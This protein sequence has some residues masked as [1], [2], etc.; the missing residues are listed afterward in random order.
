MTPGLI[1]RHQ[2]YVLGPNQ[3]GRLAS[4]AAGQFIEGLVLHLDTDAPFALR[5]RALRIAY[6]T[7]DG[8]GTQSGIQHILL[9]W[10]DEKRQF[11]SQNLIRQ[12]L[13]A[14]YYGQIG[15]PFPVYPQ[16]VYPRGGQIMVDLLNDGATALTNVYLYF[17]GVKL[18]AP[19]AVRSYAY[20]SKF[21]ALPFA[22]PV[23]RYSD[24]DGLTQIR[25]IAVTQGP[26]RQTLKIAGDADFV[27]RAMQAGNTFLDSVFEVFAQ[28]RDEDEKP[29]SNDPVHLDILCGNSGIS[30]IFPAGYSSAFVFPIAGGPNTPGLLFPEI[31]VPKNH[32]FY[33]D[34]SRSDGAYARTSAVDLPFTFIGQKVF[35]K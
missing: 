7:G 25:S 30:Q 15:N 10:A 31:Y 35:Q 14:P 22:Y 27:M 21:G 6:T 12:T 20:P 13:V 33:V 24:T 26:L 8:Q 29:Y 11:R 5:S 34:I 28:L 9:R 23:G 16:V 4:V 17:R 2:D 18:F 32:L 3:D 1:E 19:G